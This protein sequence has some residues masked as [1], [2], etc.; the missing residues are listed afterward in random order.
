M[1]EEN[2][3]P[4]EAELGLDGVLGPAVQTV[5]QLLHGD[6]TV[7]ADVTIR[8]IFPASVAL[9]AVFIGYLA[10]KYL[11]RVISG[12]VCKRVD[13]TLGK[14]I[15]RVVFYGVLLTVVASVL[16]IVGFRMGGIATI[17]AAAGFAIGLAFQGTLS[18]FAAGVLLLVFRPFKVGDLINAAGMLGKVNEIDLF[19]TTLDTP[20]HRRIIIPNSSISGGTIENISFHQH[21]RVEVVIGVAYAASLD[22][23]RAALIAAAESLLPIM[24]QGEGRGYKVILAG[25]AA[26]SVQWKVRVWAATPDSFDVTEKLTQAIKQQLDAAGITIP[27][28][29]MDVHLHRVDSAE[30][31]PASARTRP[32]LSVT[33]RDFRHETDGPRQASD[34]A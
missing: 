19:T 22:A 17:L 26:S 5:Q 18:N 2:G 21:R 12:P 11:A 23:T 31:V 27:F 33:A 6:P 28:P 24:I 10:A 30:S 4:V 1:T 15:G 3:P 34:A 14:F 8:Y 7:L 16:N 20:D 9:L 25:M 32:R 29:Q 13:E